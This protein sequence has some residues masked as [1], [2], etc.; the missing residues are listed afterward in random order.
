MSDSSYG[1][2]SKIKYGSNS[3]LID[4]KNRWA[5][6]TDIWGI[7]K[8]KN[9]FNLDVDAIKIV[10]TPPTLPYKFPYSFTQ[11]SQINQCDKLPTLPDGVTLHMVKKQLNER[12]KIMG[13]TIPFPE[14][15]YNYTKLYIILLLLLVV[16]VVAIYAMTRSS[17]TG[18][19]PITP[20]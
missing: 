1:C 10:E 18:V 13:L 6:K 9:L 7:N 15:E 11:A 14:V 20:R 8:S 2:Q 19:A 17:K 16:V 4:F 12:A 3:E 5:T